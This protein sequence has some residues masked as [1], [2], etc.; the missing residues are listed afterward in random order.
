MNLPFIY[1]GTREQIWF[2]HK[3][4]PLN[5]GKEFIISLEEFFKKDGHGGLDR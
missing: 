1:R 4:E 5:F 3:E 2:Q